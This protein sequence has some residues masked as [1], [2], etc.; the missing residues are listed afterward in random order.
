[1]E[2]FLQ[3]MVPNQG[4]LGTLYCLFEMFVYFDIPDLND[5]KTCRRAKKQL[6]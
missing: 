6:A 2:F 1:M 5:S 3:N 4:P